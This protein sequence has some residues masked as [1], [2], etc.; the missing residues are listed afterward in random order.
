MNPPKD[1]TITK[2][3]QEPPM[4]VENNQWILGSPTITSKTESQSASIAI[5][6]DTWQRNAEQKK[7]NEKRGY[8]LNTTRKGI[9]QR[10]AK[11][12]RR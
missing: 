3:E 8:V 1:A 4:V 6:T 11:E 2:R 5:S 10:T 12:S 9:S 7:R